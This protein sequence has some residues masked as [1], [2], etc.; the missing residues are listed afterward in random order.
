[1]RAISSASG[2]MKRP[3]AGP[4]GHGAESRPSDAR[5]PERGDAPVEHHRGP[6][7]GAVEIDRLEILVLLQP[8][9]VKH[10]ARQDRKTRARRP[11]RHG[12]ADEIA[13]GFVWTVR[14]HDEHAGT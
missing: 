3:P 8:E 5:A 12:L 1:M 13:D 9:P 11:E 4:R 6:V 2:A 10:V 7:A 14:A